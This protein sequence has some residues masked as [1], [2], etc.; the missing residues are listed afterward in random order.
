MYLSNRTRYFTKTE[1]EELSQYF[2]EQDIT[3]STFV[4][5]DVD[6]SI[7]GST[8]DYKQGSVSVTNSDILEVEFSTDFNKRM[9]TMSGGVFSTTG[10]LK[11]NSDVIRGTLEVS[12]NGEV[13]MSVYAGSIQV[14]DK[15]AASGIVSTLTKRK[16]QLFH[17]AG[18]RRKLSGNSLVSMK[19]VAEMALCTPKSN[20]R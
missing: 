13:V 9:F 7:S 3:E 14:N 17:G 18:W 4:A 20:Q 2:I 8:Y 12:D 15:T 5:T 19:S 1:Q 16:I 6:T 10:D 11:I